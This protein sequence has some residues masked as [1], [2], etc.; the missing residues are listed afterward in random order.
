MFREKVAANVK[1]L[2]AKSSDE[3]EFQK[4]FQRWRSY[5]KLACYFLTIGLILATANYEMGFK[6]DDKS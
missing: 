6:M 3:H 5:E 4:Y 1:K 2:G